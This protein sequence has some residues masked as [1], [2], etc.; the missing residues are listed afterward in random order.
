[1]APPGPSPRAEPIDHLRDDVR[2]LG[3]LLGEVLRE[4][5]GVGLFQ[6][7]E[8]LRTEAI[9]LRSGEADPIRERSLL[10]WVQRQP[11]RRLLQLVR[12]FGVYFH[13]VNL[14]EQRHRVRTLRER[15]QA[16]R[17]VEES[18]L[19]AVKALSRHSI[20]AERLRTVVRRL[21]VHPVFTAHPSEVRRRTLLHHL[22]QAAG[23]IERLDAPL[24]VPSEREAVLEELRVR[25]TLIWQSA[26][27]RVERPSVLDEV[28]SAVYVLA[29]SVYDLAPRVWRALEQALAAGYESE[30]VEQPPLRLGSW[31]GGDRDG[32]PAV[33]PDV[34]RAAARL[35]RV[36][37]LRRYQRELEELGRDLSISAR[38]VSASTELQASIERERT[39]LGLQPV[40]RWRDEPYRRRLGLIGERVRRAET[41]ETG[42]YA[43]AEELLADLDELIR[44]LE[45]HQGQ[46]VARGRLLDLRRR[47]ETFGFHLAELEIRQ[48][49][50]RHTAAVAELLGLVG[51]PGYAGMDEDARLAVLEECLSG[52]LLDV[53]RPA[54]SAETREVLDTFVAAADLQRMGG[55]RACQTCVVSMARAGSDALAVLFL[56]REAGL[57]E[58]ARGGPGMPT[59][60]RRPPT[61]EEAPDGEAGRG[62]TRRR[63]GVEPNVVC[64]L[65]VVPLFEQVDELAQCGEIMRRLFRSRVYRAAVRV[66]GDRQQV[67]RGYS[68]SDKDGGYLASV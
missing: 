24:L 62:A 16:G 52:G 14:A 64:K 54:L 17:P 65:D 27:T 6:A 42:G 47:V 34:T 40:A 60:D 10:R 26:E 31:V 18:M 63:D 9:A 48:H 21:V 30:R 51:V 29:G 28:H 55:P 12:A 59:A 57:F 13:L 11:T 61:A 5:G 38:L 2:L 19:A 36:A 4:Q 32:N 7:V 49:A 58:V 44:S 50:E 43:T 15:E 45:A 20:S 41:G 22:A 68:D 39:R 46:R 3:E 33:T 23:L 66:R 8:R 35:A 25:T 67:M 56:A 53:P 37:V 1:M